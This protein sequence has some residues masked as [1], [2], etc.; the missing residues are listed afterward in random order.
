MSSMGADPSTRKPKPHWYAA[1]SKY[2]RP[3]LRR[4]VWQLFDTFLPY[5]AL[6]V[7]MAYT[8][9]A[10]YSYWITLALALPAAFLL[11]RVFIFF[12]DCCHN[13]FFAS[14]RANRILGVITGVAVFTPFQEWRGSH[15][16][17][18][19]TAGD[20]DRRGTG[21]VWTMT[22]EEY[23]RAAGLKR[24]AYRVYRNPLMMFG[25]GP[26]FTFLLRNRFSH[27]GAGKS[28]RRSVIVT[29]LLLLGVAVAASLAM[30]L[31]A[32]LIIQ[33]PV[34]LLAGV[35]GIWLFY[36]QHQFE[37]VYW[38]R[39]AAW[40]PMKASLKGASYYRLPKVLQWLTGNIGF[41]HIHH[42][43]PTIPNYNLARCYAGIPALR[44]VEPLTIR[45]SLKSLGM[46]LWDEKAHRLVSF[47]SAGRR[48]FPNRRR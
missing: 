10:G 38:A 36:V 30:G 5:I 37:G 20:L 43:R 45:T 28:E 16:K 27:K 18:H 41:H 8:V 19:R 42:I 4:A 31:R 32:Y 46:R 48:R 23:A 17:H 33:L 29:N 24:L 39:H 47:R 21:D 35:I 13:S 40:D 15:L 1:V 3:D 2:S 7:L 6:W 34:I 22:L 14:R 12:H 44:D 25:M 26:V 11:V 9:R